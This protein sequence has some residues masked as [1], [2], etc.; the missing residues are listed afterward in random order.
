MNSIDVIIGVFLVL[1]V[2][3]G[4]RNGFLIELS[5]L[6]GLVLGVWGAIYFSHFASDLLIKYTDW[7][8][9][10][11]NL[12]AFAITF[13]GIVMLVS[14]LSR[15]LTKVASFAA[16]G[17]LN[18]LLGGIFGFLKM[19]F[20]ASVLMLFTNS[21]GKEIAF[22]SQEKKEASMLYKP[23]ESI[24]PMVLPKLLK[25]YQEYFPEKNK[26]DSPLNSGDN[27]L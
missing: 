18:R 15:A 23:I 20:F 11:I 3:Q 10:T 22:L 26:E 1:G 19:A 13:I 24:A 4:L 12:A 14:L 16:L 27:S 7:E 25:E 2:I 5:S 9:Q 21:L 8:E 17:M 6:I